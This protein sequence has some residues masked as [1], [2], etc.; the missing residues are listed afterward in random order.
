MKCFL[1]SLSIVLLIA[2]FASG[3][4]SAVQAEGLVGT[5]QRISLTNDGQQ[6][7]NWSSSPSISADGRYVAFDSMA[8]N[9]FNPD[10]NG[11][12]DVFVYDRQA[13]TTEVVSIASDGTPGNGS[14]KD[15]VLSADGRYV[16]FLSGSTNLISGVTRWTDNVFVHDRL[17]GLT[18][19][20]NIANDGTRAN[21]YTRFT[22]SI[23]ADG[24]YVAFDSYA[25]N[26]VSG[27]NNDMLDVF[28]HDRQT[29]TTERVSVRSDGVQGNDIS[30][31]PALSADGRFV[32]FASMSSNFVEAT[33]P[34]SVEVYLRDRVTGT[35]ELISVASDGTPAADA[36]IPAPA[37]ISADGRLV[38]F[39]SDASNLVSDDTNGVMDVFLRDRL[40]G[41]TERVSVASDGAQANA[42]TDTVSLSGDGRY[43]AFNSY[44]SNLV[45]GDTNDAADIFVHDRLTGITERVSVASDGSQGD[46]FTYQVSISGNGQV[47]SFGSNATNLV[48]G[49][50]N[51]KSDVFIRIRPEEKTNLPV[52]ETMTVPGAPVQ[53]GT[54]V[55]TSAVFSDPDLNQTYTAE[56]DWGDGT[57]TPAVLNGFSITGEHVYQTP[58]VYPLRL[59]VNDPID[60]NASA[61]T[62]AI[63][64]YDLQGG[65]LSGKGS[66]LSP[67]GAYLVDPT[68]T[69]SATLNLSAK[70]ENGAAVP[71]G[72]TQLKFGA[73]QITFKSSSYDWLIVNGA[74][75]T[76]KGSGTINGAGEYEFKVWVVDGAAAS[77]TVPDLVRI[78]IWEKQS[79]ATIYDT[80]AMDPESASPVTEVASGNITVIKG[81]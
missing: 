53:A 58:G 33:N 6:T 1:R 11:W 35:T 25:T 7:N 47:V 16:A 60:G 4:S 46:A 31:H 71:V 67:A 20:V 77:Q 65:N 21:D 57:I 18:E 17:T 40:T 3:L 32:A 54:S 81:K 26:L 66:F 75:A 27:D 30:V 23:S 51:G 24:R 52:I 56:W 36:Y 70:Y 73:A 74:S 59:T 2:L 78:K 19:L 28:V 43:V 42:I 55:Q 14:S 39:L 72:N 79:G 68:L 69:G 45:S 13:G 50:S 38:A 61:T 10:T 44:A 41:I 5:T 29:G 48:A 64:V 9:L 12:Y 62:D 34:G 22:P 8:T 15:P 37:S 63:V 80:Q 49:D 76:Y